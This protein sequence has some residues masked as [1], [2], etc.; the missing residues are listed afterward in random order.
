METTCYFDFTGKGLI[1]DHLCHKKIDIEGFQPHT[2]DTWELIYIKT[3]SVSYLVEGR[4]YTAESGNCILTRPGIRHTI[5]FR[6]FDLY[7]RYAILVNNPLF[8]TI[9]ETMEVINLGSNPIISDLFQKMD[10]YA[11]YLDMDALERVMLHLT[12][13]ALLNFKILSDQLPEHY[14]ANAT[15]TKA[16]A[17]IDMNLHKQI[18]LEELCL[19]LHITK[20]H[21]HR[22]FMEHL[23]LPPAKYIMS[24]RLHKAR[25]TIR[26]GCKPT[27]VYQS[28]GFGDYCTFYRNYSR[29]FGYPPSEEQDR[30]NARQIEW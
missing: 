29:Q 25:T 10:F 13:E 6:D 1:A 12:E 21:L 26:A 11:G 15:V 20:S 4:C 24:K 22:L 3:G 28:C 7:D 5:R 8:D 2:H 30:P 23:Q 14:T 18:S 16:I 9:P 17:Y 19:S 27:R